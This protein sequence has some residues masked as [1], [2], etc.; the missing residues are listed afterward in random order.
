LKTLLD[1]IDAEGW[2]A[3]PRNPARHKKV[4][5]MLPPAETRAGPKVIVHLPPEDATA[6]F[7]CR[8]VASEL[9]VVFLVAVTTG[10]RDGELHGLRVSNVVL[11]GKYPMLRVREALA[12][13]SDKGRN[14]LQGLKT[15]VSTR[16]M[17]L[18][19]LAVEVLRWW[20]DV[21]WVRWVGRRP[22]P[23]DFLFPNDKGKPRR[24]RSAEQ[25]RTALRR[26]GRPDTYEGHNI[27][28]HALRRSFSTA[29]QS[30]PQ[31]AT[32]KHD[33]MGHSGKGADQRH[34]VAV[35]MRVKQEAVESIR[36]DVTL[37]DISNGDA[38]SPTSGV[39]AAVGES[40]DVG[41]DMPQEVR[42]QP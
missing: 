3:I 6:L 9:K 5:E 34:Y 25:L 15:K 28:M 19:T 33:L 18:Q 21:G 7:A 36:L 8:K 31:V 37:A 10:L 35:S 38:A 20:L 26:A 4:V 17:P 12:L 40:G 23:E 1:D 16:D 39:N 13:E 2:F 14:T 32:V 24:P 27:T 41:A 30:F 11:D 29:L 42:C 22:T